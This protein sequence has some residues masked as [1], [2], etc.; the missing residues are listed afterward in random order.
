M[1]THVGETF[2]GLDCG[3]H[4]EDRKCLQSQPLKDTIAIVALTNDMYTFYIGIFNAR[5]SDNDPRLRMEVKTS[6]GYPASLLLHSRG[7]RL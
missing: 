2:D 1:K 3:G 7:E 4:D 5:T 6:L